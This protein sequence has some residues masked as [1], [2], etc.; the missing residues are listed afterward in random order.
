MASAALPTGPLSV[1]RVMVGAPGL[2]ASTFKT[3]TSSALADK[4]F[5]M[6]CEPATEPD[7]V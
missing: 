4:P 7:I 2:I 5:A 1:A 6:P 3:S